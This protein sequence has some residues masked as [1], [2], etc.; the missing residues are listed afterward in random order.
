MTANPFR[1]R[2]AQLPKPAQRIDGPRI[3]YGTRA[4]VVARIRTANGEVPQLRTTALAATARMVN[5][6]VN[7]LDERDLAA[8]TRPKY[9]AR[10]IE[11]AANH[12]AIEQLS[13]D[14]A[15]ALISTLKTLPYKTATP[16][17]DTDVPAGRYAFT[18]ADG[19]TVFV[20]VDQPIAG[21]WAG[22]TFVT[23]QLSDDF[24]RMTRTQ[25][26]DA[27]KAIL[28]LGVKESALRYGKELGVCSVCA[29]TLTNEQSRAAGIGPV[30]AGNMGW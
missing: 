3:T 16:A 13:M 18:G 23:R 30:C 26:A 27:L 2:L 14:Q 5:L 10:M 22:Y 24:A 25:Q 8:E 11:L 1:D 19:T 20:K 21:K 15:S 17:T 9:Q 6:I 7:L 4:D 12:Q 28:A 29:R